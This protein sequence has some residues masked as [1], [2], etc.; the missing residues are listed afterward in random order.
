MRK[1]QYF[2]L[3]LISISIILIPFTSFS[4][5]SDEKDFDLLLVLTQQDSEMNWWFSVPS[6]LGPIISKIDK[7]SKGEYF[8]ILPIFNNWGKNEKNEVNIT[9]DVSILKPDG[10]TYETEK[11][12]TGFKGPAPGPF[13]LPSLGMLYVWSQN[14]S[15]HL[16]LPL[17]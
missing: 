1:I 10:T 7:V 11:N 5:E 6:S 4:K 9:Y 2:Y 12:V 13:L 8:N 3:L 16:K 15:G 17:T 14:V